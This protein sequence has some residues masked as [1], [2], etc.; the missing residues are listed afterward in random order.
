MGFV[1]FKLAQYT[2][3]TELDLFP[4]LEWEKK[5]FI[6]GAVINFFVL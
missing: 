6:S 5:S 4:A 3:Q 1:K 2:I